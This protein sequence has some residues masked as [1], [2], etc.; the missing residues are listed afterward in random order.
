MLQVR[1]QREGKS[2]QSRSNYCDCN[3]EGEQDPPEAH[4]LGT[5]TA[6]QVTKVSTARSRMPGHVSDRVCSHGGQSGA[7]FL[8]QLLLLERPARV[9]PDTKGRAMMRD[10]RQRHAAPAADP[11]IRWVRHGSGCDGV[12]G[13]DGFTYSAYSTAQALPE[14]VYGIDVNLNV[15]PSC[16][17]IALTVETAHPGA[18]RNGSASVMMYSIVAKHSFI[19]SSTRRSFNQKSRPH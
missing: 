3:S 12:R 4:L 2:N 14:L 18:G 6:Q 10:E 17:N 7:P 9:C 8:L 15:T 5:I 11:A 19:N 13:R 16:K 1:S